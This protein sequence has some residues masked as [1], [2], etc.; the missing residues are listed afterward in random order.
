MSGLDA[1]DTAADHVGYEALMIACVTQAIEDYLDGPGDDATPSLGHSKKAHRRSRR[2]VYEEARRYIFDNTQESL[3]N[4]FG[5]AFILLSL[6]IDPDTARKSILRRTRC[7]N[8]KK[9]AVPLDPMYAFPE[10]NRHGESA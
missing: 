2:K 4:I 9:E 5:F 3:E 10:N 7:K 1:A 6:G 8:T